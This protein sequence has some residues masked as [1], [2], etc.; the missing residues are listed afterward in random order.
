MR[1]HV[2]EPHRPVAA[3]AATL[4]PSGLNATS[5]IESRRCRGHGRARR[6]SG[7]PRAPRSPLSTATRCARRARSGALRRSRDGRPSP[8]RAARGS[9]TSQSRTAPSSAS[10]IASVRP[11]GLNATLG[12][13]PVGRRRIASRP[14][15]PSDS[16]ADTTLF[17][18]LDRRAR[19][20]HTA[21]RPR[22]SDTSRSARRAGRSPLEASATDSA[23][24]RWSIAWLRWTSA[25]TRQP[26]RDARAR[27][28][29]RANDS[30]CRRDV[31]RRLASDVAALAARVG[32]GSLPACSP[33]QASAS[34]RSLP[35]SRKLASRPRRSHSPARRPRRVCA[36]TQSASTPSASTQPRRRGVELAVVPEV[37][38]LRHDAARPGSAARV[39]VP[40]Q[41]AAAGACPARARGRA[42]A[43]SAARRPS[44]GSAR[45]T[46]VSDAS[47][48][49]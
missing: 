31:A 35:R 34:R 43:G 47:M 40:A 18:G 45:T 8:C 7:R 21:S 46:N 6:A 13:T 14:R 37:D 28:A 12:P 22:S 3:A 9:R 23:R 42:R 39:D 15:S 27:P 2:P 5:E 29:R 26:D 48:P 32:G 36:R 41:H 11:S 19:R 30:R 44:P 33:S 16:S 25:K 20:P 24:S 1:A 49:R 17:L 38:P 4:P 10:P